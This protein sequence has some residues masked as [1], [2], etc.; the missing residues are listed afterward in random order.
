MCRCAASEIAPKEVMSINILAQAQAHRY[1]F[2][3]AQ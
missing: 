3:A 1:T 2:I